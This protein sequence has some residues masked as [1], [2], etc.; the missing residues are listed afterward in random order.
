MNVSIHGS[1]GLLKRKTAVLCVLL[2]LYA[3]PSLFGEIFNTATVLAPGQISLGFDGQYYIEPE[4]TIIFIHFGFGLARDTADLRIS[5]GFPSDD[6]DNYVGADLEFV[7]SAG[8]P[9]VSLAVGGHKQ[10]DSALDLTLLFSGKFDT[11]EPYFGFDG[12]YIF[13]DNDDYYF[14][15]VLLGIEIRFNYTAGFLLEY[16]SMIATDIDNENFDMSYFSL[17]VSIYF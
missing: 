10:D 6:R 2:F 4:E 15:N 16:G 3:I 8:G 17:G 11:I 5:A 13:N 1:I 14:I 7:L 12:N 9:A